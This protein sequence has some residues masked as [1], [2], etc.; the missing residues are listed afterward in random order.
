MIVNSHLRGLSPVVQLSSRGSARSRQSWT[1]SSAGRSRAA[2]RA[3][4]AAAAEFLP[5]SPCAGRPLRD[6]VARIRCSWLSPTTNCPLAKLI[7]PPDQA[8]SHSHGAVASTGWRS[9]AS[10]GVTCA[11]PGQQP[12]VEQPDADQHRAKPDEGQRA[13]HAFQFGHVEQEHFCH[14]RCDHHRRCSADD[15]RPSAHADR[16]AAPR[17]S[18]AKVRN[19]NRS[20][21]GPAPSRLPMYSPLNS[22]RTE[23]VA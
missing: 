14:R 10:G 18:P 16:P 5:G 8:Q 17:P 15:E 4:S 2:A 20:R 6:A 9:L 21:A 1:R 13:Q 11:D 12:L 22:R 7:Q 23:N 3:R 19:M